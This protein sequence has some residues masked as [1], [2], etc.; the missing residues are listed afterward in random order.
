VWIRISILESPN[1]D[2]FEKEKLNQKKRPKSALQ[3]LICRPLQFFVFVCVTTGPGLNP[4][5]CCL[6]GGEQIGCS[7]FIDSK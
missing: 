6:R 5:C 1:R 2:P 4:P 7:Q 3:L